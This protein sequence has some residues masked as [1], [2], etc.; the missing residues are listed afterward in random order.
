[1][2]ARELAVPGLLTKRRDHRIVECGHLPT[3]LIL[4]Q[5]ANADLPMCG[6]LLSVWTNESTELIGDMGQ[7]NVGP[8]KSNL[9]FLCFECRCLRPGFENTAQCLFGGIS[10]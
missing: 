9:D 10:S 4:H 8:D 2:A 5:D 1:M 3:P 7:G 6:Q